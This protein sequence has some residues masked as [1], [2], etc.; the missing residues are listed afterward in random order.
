MKKIYFVRH[1]ESEGNASPIRKGIMSSLSEKGKEQARSI[2]Q[3]CADIPIELLISSTVNRAK[4]T[5][6]IISEKIHKPVE[7]SDL[8]IE[9]RRPS[10]VYGKPKNDPTALHVENEIVKNFSKEGW[11]YSNED[12]FDDLKKRAL[13]ALD[14]LANRPEEN[15][16]VVSHGFFLRIV[17]ACV[18]HGSELTGKEC[19]GFIRTFHMENTGMT[20]LCC[21]E[22]NKDN[23]WW[24]WI[25]NDHAHLD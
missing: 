25:W 23:P 22:K 20:V 17:M 6:E 21:D 3:R 12:N 5:A 14:Y 15:I 2:A 1:G 11:R 24:L 8:F 16:L 4:E 7:L 18:V 13:E 10:E 9:R 19:E